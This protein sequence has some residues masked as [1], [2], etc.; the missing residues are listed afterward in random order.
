MSARLI[1]LVFAVLLVL[2]GCSDEEENPLTPG[3]G[4]NFPVSTLPFPD[5]PEQL[6]ANFLKIYE[7]MD[8]DEYKLILDPAFETLLQQATQNE[9]PGVGST[10]NAAEENRLHE[11]MFLGEPL[12]DANG[13]VLPAVLS[14]SFSRFQPRVGWGVS[15][16]TDPIPNTLSALYE[17]EILADR[18]QNYST[19]FVRGTIR[20]YVATAE[21]KLDGQPKTYY[22][23]I[24]QLDLTEFSKDAQHTAWGSLKALYY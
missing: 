1:V 23:L 10:L 21:G 16:P 17:V 18:G 11:R 7:T 4:D 19:Q 9:F 5:T 14:I 2:S 6:M 22:R 13:G 24:G 3:T 12:L 15:L 20:F 8:A